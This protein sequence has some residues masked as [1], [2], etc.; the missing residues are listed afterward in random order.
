MRTFYIRLEH[1][2]T[3][4]HSFEKAFT[5]KGAYKKALKKAKGE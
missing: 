2:G 1:E 4:Y 5:F 3:I